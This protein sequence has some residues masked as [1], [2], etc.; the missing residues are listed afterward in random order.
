MKIWNLQASCSGGFVS[1]LS[2]MGF[3]GWGLMRVEQGFSAGQSRSAATSPM[4][5]CATCGTPE[6]SILVI[7]CETLISLCIQGLTWDQ[8][9][10][11]AK[12]FKSEQSDEAAEV[13]QSLIGIAA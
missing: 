7:Q 11:T 5:S 13:N 1:I 4:V 6:S 8:E 12:T 2:L 10:G 9:I 3:N